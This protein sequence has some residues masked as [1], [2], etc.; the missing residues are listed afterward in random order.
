MVTSRSTLEDRG[1]KRL[2]CYIDVRRKL[3]VHTISVK[4][5]Q[6]EQRCKK[7][8]VS[9]TGTGHP[10]NVFRDVRE[11]RGLGTGARTGENDAT[12]KRDFRWHLPHPW[13]V[14]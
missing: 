8:F 9:G 3:F 6:D 12:T 7:W 2:A 14:I 1:Q 4:H 10:K 5:R 11:K 13:D